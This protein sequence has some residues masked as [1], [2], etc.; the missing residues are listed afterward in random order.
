MLHDIQEQR[1]FICEVIEAEKNISN[2]G[3]KRKKTS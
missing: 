2:E 3:D 1:I